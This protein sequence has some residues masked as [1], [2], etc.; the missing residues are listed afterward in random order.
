MI[1]KDKTK[2]RDKY[3]STS[4]QLEICD[5]CFKTFESRAGDQL[6]PQCYTTSQDVKLKELRIK[7]NK[8]VLYRSVVTGESQKQAREYILAIAEGKL[9][10]WKPTSK[11]NEKQAVCNNAG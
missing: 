6:C 2:T 1:L 10:G 4:Y 9:A 3:Q 8:L 7:F 5:K 11:Q